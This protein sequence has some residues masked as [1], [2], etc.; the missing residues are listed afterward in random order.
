M[1]DYMWVVGS[2]DYEQ[3]SIDGIYR[4]PA[5]AEAAIKALYQEPY[6][7]TWEPTKYDDWMDDGS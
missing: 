1:T 7:V 4:S 2:G 5:D 3:R 6:V